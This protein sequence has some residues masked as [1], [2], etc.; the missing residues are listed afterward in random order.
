MAVLPPL[1]KKVRHIACNKEE[2]SNKF[3]LFSVDFEK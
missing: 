1:P 3:V 2:K